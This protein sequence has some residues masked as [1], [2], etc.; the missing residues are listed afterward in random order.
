MMRS[1]PQSA[2]RPHRFEYELTA[3]GSRLYL[4]RIL[5]VEDELLVGLIIEE[6][7]RELGCRIARVAHTVSM[8]RAELHKGD[9]DAAL[10]DLSMG[11]GHSLQIADR[12]LSEGIPFAFVTGY[13]YL[14][15]TRHDKVPV[16]LKPFTPTQLGDV[17]AVLARPTSQQTIGR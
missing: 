17:L 13:D 9:F 14:V 6:M 12:L 11:H 5:I 1:Y 4:P 8:A 10:L 16:L 15:E 2:L 7:C 3:P